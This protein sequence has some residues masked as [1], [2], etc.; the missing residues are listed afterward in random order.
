MNVVFAP[1]KGRRKKRWMECVRPKK[2]WRIKGESKKM[3]SD[4]R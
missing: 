2:R 4:S 3:T 1:I